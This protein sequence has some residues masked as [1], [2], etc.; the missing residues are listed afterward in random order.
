MPYDHAIIRL[1]GGRTIE[2]STTRE[3]RRVY[4]EE[5]KVI[6]VG[7]AEAVLKLG[8][9]QVDMEVALWLGRSVKV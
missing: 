9:E 2:A 3:G 5:G 6:A 8:R 1:S 4:L 7:L